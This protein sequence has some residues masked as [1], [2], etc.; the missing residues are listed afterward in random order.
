MKKL[1][2]KLVLFIFLFSLVGC[3]SKEEKAEKHINRAIKYI[4]KNEMKS[5]FIEYKNAIKILPNSVKAHYGLGE[6][7]LK[8]GD[9]TSAIEEFRKSIDLDPSHREARIKLVNLYLI[10]NRPKKAIDTLK[11]FLDVK[12]KKIQF[13]Y[14]KSLYQ[15]KKY[16]E[17]EVRLLKLIKDNPEFAAPYLLLARYYLSDLKDPKKCEIV[18]KEGIINTKD[19]GIWLFLANFYALE[20]R[21][22]EAERCY[23]DMIK[24]K[25]N[26]FNLRKMFIDYLVRLNKYKKAKNEI[27]KLLVLFPNNSKVFIY[28]GDYYANQK[29][30]HQAVKYYLKAQKDKKMHLKAS[31]KLASLYFYTNKKKEAQKEIDKILKEDPKNLKALF[32]KS[33]ICLDKGQIDQ[34]IEILTFLTK[35]RPKFSKAYFLLGK[36]YLRKRED[37]L[38]EVNFQKAISLDPNFYPAYIEISKLYLSK[39]KLSLAQDLLE[40][41]LK[42]N[43][44]GLLAHLLIGDLFLFKKD[45]ENAALHYKKLISLYPKEYLGYLRLGILN[46][47]MKKNNIAQAYFKEA[48]HFNPNSKS[49][50]LNITQ[51]YKNVDEAI[52]FLKNILEKTNNRAFVY[53]VIG[54]VY[55]KEKD[56]KKA[57]EYFKTS[58]VENKNFLPSY[59]K[60]ADVYII[61]NKIDM[62]I[63]EYKHMISLNHKDAFSY[64]MLGVLY[65]KKEKRD[66]ANRYYKNALK[67][68]NRFVLAANNLAWNY[69]QEDKNLDKALNLAQLAYEIVPDNPAISDTL[70]MAYLKKGFYL[71]AIPLFEE[72]LK[73]AVG[74]DKE[75]ILYHIGLAYFKKGN[76]EKAK[77]YFKKAI[78]MNKSE[79][80]EK[81]IKD[82][83]DSLEK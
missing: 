44:K 43:S 17:A 52:S 82:I 45:F 13:L 33:K 65:D 19:I 70:G 22:I 50:L 73:T 32:L 23:R 16:E 12:D 74:K 37:N 15:L 67:I 14:A 69:I 80:I 25:P 57:E 11:P 61:Q 6:L 38:A 21:D 71:M 48:L 30:F 56:F 54:S 53:F 28:V 10:F 62:A 78:N 79:I 35:Q 8:I 5:A 76:L 36:A 26:S 46:L 2:V 60:L 7:F 75:V 4:K 59:K 64:A 18:L 20:K 72:A 77:M 49:A 27:K 55:L 66:I 34:A 51:T 68:D 81:K 58:I 24:T 41:A 29:E 83:L 39:G 9:F 63:D 3:L 42:I 47:L 40:N 1:L 31:V